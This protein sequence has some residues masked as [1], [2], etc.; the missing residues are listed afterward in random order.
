MNYLSDTLLIEAY[1]E[2]VKLGLDSDFIQMIKEEL[3]KR[4]VENKQIIT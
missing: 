1:E 3:S 4:N 2:A